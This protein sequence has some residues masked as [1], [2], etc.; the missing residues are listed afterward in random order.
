MLDAPRVV[1]TADVI[2]PREN[3]RSVCLWR[4]SIKEADSWADSSIK[5]STETSEVACF[6]LKVTREEEQSV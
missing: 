2:G 6:G 1:A 5:S 4:V 3:L